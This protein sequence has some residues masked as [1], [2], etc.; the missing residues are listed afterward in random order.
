[1]LPVYRREYGFVED[2]SARVA[3]CGFDL[4]WR[5]DIQEKVGS[6]KLPTFCLFMSFHVL[7]HVHATV[8]L[9]NLTCDV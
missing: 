5:R 7:L 1:M 8:D 6:F 4:L 2:V 9:D 3:E